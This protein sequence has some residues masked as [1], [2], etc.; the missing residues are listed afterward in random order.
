MYPPKF[1]YYRAGSLDEAV[2]LLK[3]HSGAKL[4]AG[5]HSLLPAMKLRLSEPGALI[6]IGRIEP[7]KGML[8]NRAGGWDLGAL[9]THAQIQHGVSGQGFEALAETASGVGDPQVRNRGTI[10]GNIAHADPASD[11]PTVLVA[12]GAIISVVGPNG[13]RDIAASD[14]FVDFFATALTD[15][16]IIE[17]IRIPALNSPSNHGVGSAYVK[18]ENPASRYSL[19]GA[20]AVVQ[21]EN[22]VCA[23]A[24]VAVGG[25]TPRAIRASAVEAALTGKT[26][27][28]ATIEAAAAKISDDLGDE[29]N[30]DLHATAEYRQAMAPLYVARAIATAAERAK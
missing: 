11:W 1:D 15:D 8:V 5:G 29:V 26:L 6:D 25:L 19:V 17:R 9:V 14:F 10:G 27:D 3:E 13:R 16:E 28:Q 21:V 7:L 24:G 12:F 18:M 22:G 23:K 30:G 4:L 20:A 2:A